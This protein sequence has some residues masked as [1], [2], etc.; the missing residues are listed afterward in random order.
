MKLHADMNAAKL[1]ELRSMPTTFD[2]SVPGVEGPATSG[3]TLRLRACVPCW[4]VNKGLANQ[5]L[6]V[7]TPR[8]VRDC[9]IP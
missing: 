7:K 6:G 8:G 2:F 9:R 5:P 3:A 4:R 1:S